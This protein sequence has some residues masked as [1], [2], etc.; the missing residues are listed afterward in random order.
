M[1]LMKSKKHIRTDDAPEKRVELHMHTRFSALDAITDPAAIVERA[2]YWG[3]RILPEY[4]LFHSRSQEP[5]SASST[6]LEL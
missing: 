6:Y 5:M 1:S 2:G 3:M 4:L